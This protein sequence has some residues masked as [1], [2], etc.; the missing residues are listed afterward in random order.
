MAKILVVDDS[1][2]ARLM[3]KQI[4]KETFPDWEIYDVANGDDALVVTASNTDIDIAILDYNMP[5]M[6]GL[7]LAEK[8]IKTCPIPRMALLTA[9]IQ[10]HVK[11]HA[12]PLGLTFLNKPI[13]EEIVVPYLST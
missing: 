11:E 3:L 13:Q 8:I 4:I 9:N 12:E 10:D 2:V 5:G 6:T 1:L 7:E